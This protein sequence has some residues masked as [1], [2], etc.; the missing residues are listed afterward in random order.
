MLFG[1]T[2]VEM[3]SAHCVCSRL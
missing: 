1:H 3:M 2:V